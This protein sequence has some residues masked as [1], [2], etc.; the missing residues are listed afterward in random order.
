MCERSTKNAEKLEI[1]S[2]KGQSVKSKIKN[3][4]CKDNTL[5]KSAIPAIFDGES[6]DKQAER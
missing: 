6:D 3:E 2:K 1:I 4:N 5:Y